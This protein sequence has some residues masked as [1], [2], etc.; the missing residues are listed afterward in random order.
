MPFEI[1]A[2]YGNIA[3]RYRLAINRHDDW[4]G[5]IPSDGPPPQFL[6]LAGIQRSSKVR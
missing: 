1:G 3:A 6:T 2:L 4:H 5:K